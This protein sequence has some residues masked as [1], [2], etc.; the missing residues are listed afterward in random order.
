MLKPMDP[1]S[2]PILAQ[3]REEANL[4]F[5]RFLKRQCRL[6]TEELDTTV[7]EVT[8]QV[9]ADIDCT[10][11]ANFCKIFRPTFAAQDVDRLAG[12]LAIS[13]QEL[14]DT[15][16]EEHVRDA[17]APWITRAIPSPFL[18]D[19]RCSVYQDRPEARAV[20]LHLFQ[21]EFV[22][23]TVSMVQG[24]FTCPMIYEVMERPKK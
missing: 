1:I 4:H 3:N 23:R 2:L 7:H 24:T 16:L 14:I 8:E 22:S 11:C 5:R 13:R 18:K 19:N 10:Q 12:R 17:D 20:Y 6:S 21:P 9:W 15:Y